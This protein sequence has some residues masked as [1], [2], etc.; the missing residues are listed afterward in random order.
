MVAYKRTDQQRANIDS[1]IQYIK[2]PAIELIAG[3][4]FHRPEDFNAPNTKCCCAVGA[5]AV[6]ID[7]VD[8]FWKCNGD[9]IEDVECDPDAH[10]YLAT[11]EDRY[12][13]SMND[14]NDLQHRNDYAVEELRK[15]DVIMFLEE[16]RDQTK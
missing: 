2:D 13:M 10:K 15:S 16:L 14:L 4:Y 3:H 9:S 1:L 8:L 6:Q 12:G 11:I 7:A 5:I